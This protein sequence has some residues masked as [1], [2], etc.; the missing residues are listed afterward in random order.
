MGGAKRK[1]F[2]G[3]FRQFS[4]QTQYQTK[5][6]EWNSWN[7]LLNSFQLALI[8]SLIWKLSKSPVKPLPFSPSQS[9]YLSSNNSL[10]WTHIKVNIK[11]EFL[12]LRELDRFDIRFD[13]DS[14]QTVNNDEYL[15][16][17]MTFYC[18]WYES[19]SNLISNSIEFP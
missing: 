5:Y 7:T 14:Y 6:S 2:N 16:E 18:L 4:Y 8:L 19:I 3:G 15:S 11:L 9:S 12:A 10:I 17:I 13:I 1:G